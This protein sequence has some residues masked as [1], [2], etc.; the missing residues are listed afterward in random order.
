MRTLLVLA[1]VLALGAQDQTP[2]FRTTTR[3]VELTVTERRRPA[4]AD[5]DHLPR[6]GRERQHAPHH[7]DA[8]R[9]DPRAPHAGP[10]LA[11]VLNTVGDRVA[12]YYRRA[13]SVICV[14]TST[15]QPIDRQWSSD[16][17]AR[18]VESELHVELEAPDADGESVLPK[19]R[20]VRDIRRV[21]GRVPRGT[22]LKSRNGCTDPNPLS[23]EPLAFLLPPQR[24]AYRFTSIRD[25]RERDRA[26]FVIDFVSA[27]RTS[28]PE[29]IEDE[30][31]HEDCF[32]WKGPLAARGRV[33][34]DAQTHDVLRIDRGIP[35][36]IDVRVPSLLQRRYRFDAY[37]TLDRDDVSIRF[38]P[39][40]FTDPEEVLLLP[41]TIESIT[42][43]RSGLQST[44][45]T[46]T[47]SGYRR[48]LTAARIIKDR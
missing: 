7:R 13:Q 14:E 23:P 26:A 32:D 46:E 9:E 1:V 16:G 41:E 17:I 33:W 45:R 29:L 2:T 19:A 10:D 5:P 22:D 38:R 28:R 34:V 37:V 25:G 40:A 11:T 15:V 24:D 43:V 27:D 48:F 31:G 21:N 20:I 8:A 44:R 6:A 12:H 36:P 4:D 18:T 35:G 47:F 30:R 42:I 3:L 39:V